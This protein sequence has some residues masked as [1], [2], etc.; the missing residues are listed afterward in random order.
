GYNSRLD[1]LQAALLRHAMLPRLEEWTERRRT[2][3]KRYLEGIRHSDVVVPPA[4]EGSESCWH[5][6]PVLT[7]PER[8]S[9]FREH[10]ESRGVGSGEHYPV[11]IPDQPALAHA[12]FE[13]AD[14][15][16]HARRVAASEVSLPIHPHL[17]EDEVQQVIE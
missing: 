2:I 6:F 3:A 10:L 11:A 8:K 12:A 4:P 9:A 13:L 15:C 16:A 1:E 14:N 17:T 5:L 7:P